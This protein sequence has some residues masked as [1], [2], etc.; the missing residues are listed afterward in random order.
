MAAG[1][2]LK[3]PLAGVCRPDA[4][5]PINWP[6]LEITGVSGVCSCV[7]SHFL[8]HVGSILYPRAYKMCSFLFLR[9]TENMAHGCTYTHA[10]APSEA[11]TKGSA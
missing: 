8:R 9:T 6:A 3:S 5:H 4:Q 7:R 1:L 2:L 11:L 10:E